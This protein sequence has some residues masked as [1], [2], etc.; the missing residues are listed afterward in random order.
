MAERTGLECE[1]LSDACV[2]ETSTAGSLA[3]ST[4][5]THQPKPGLVIWSKLMVSGVRSQIMY[6]RSKRPEINT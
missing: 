1:T 5:Q 6:P 4:S 2:L 3:W